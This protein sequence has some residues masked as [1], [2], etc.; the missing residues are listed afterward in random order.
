MYRLMISDW[1]IWLHSLILVLGPIRYERFL[2]KHV[3]HLP[4]V[5]PRYLTYILMVHNLKKWI[6]Y[7]WER[8]GKPVPK[9]MPGLSFSWYIEF[10]V[11]IKAL[12]RYTMA[13]HCESLQLF[14]VMHYYYSNNSCHWWLLLNSIT[15]VKAKESY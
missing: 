9:N 10:P 6:W 15:L 12:I 1:F 2:G 8:T 13:D 5:S 4:W 7:S 11:F 14:V 3:T